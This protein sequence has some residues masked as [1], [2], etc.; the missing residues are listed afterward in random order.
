[1][2]PEPVRSDQGDASRPRPMG[3]TGEQQVRSPQSGRWW[4]RRL[5][6][7]EDPRQVTSSIGAFR[8]QLEDR[9]AQCKARG[10]VDLSWAEYARQLLKQSEEALDQK[11]VDGA[12]RYLRAAQCLELYGLTPKELRVRAAALAIEV[13][14]KDLSDWRRKSVLM[15]TRQFSEGTIASPSSSPQGAGGLDSTAGATELATDHIAY[16]FQLRD[17]YR[18]KQDY[19]LTMLR[20]KLTVLLIVLLLAVVAVLGLFA[21]R[22][23]KGIPLTLSAPREGEVERG[24]DLAAIALFGFLGASLSAITSLTQL[25]TGPRIPHL[26]FHTFVTMMRPVVGAAAAL[27]LYVFLASKLLNLGGSL[28]VGLVL[29]ASFAAGFSERLIIRTVESVAGQSRESGG[30]PSNLPSVAGPSRESGGPP[31]N[32]PSVAGPS[33][34]SGGP[35]SNLPRAPI[36]G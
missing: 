6:S 36:A 12:N 2:E 14:A 25:S 21:A 31:S 8:I 13:Q 35:P 27:G 34:E 22:Q 32:L 26:R 1:M 28:S 24:S 20:E 11:D 4:W 29:A 16:A 18:D 33:R 7:F 19:R 17:E 15:I 30:P 5:L 23:I 10:E 3:M 9:V